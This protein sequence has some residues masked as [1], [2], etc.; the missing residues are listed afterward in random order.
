MIQGDF[1]TGTPPKSIEKLIK[2]S[3]GVSRTIY[4][5]SPNLGF[6]YLGFSTFYGGTSEK[7]NMY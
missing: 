4:V 7:I 1:F 2:G 6:P 3:V 5:D